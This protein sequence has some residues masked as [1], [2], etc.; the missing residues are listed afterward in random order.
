M[1]RIAR[2]LRRRRGETPG[3]ADARAALARAEAARDEVASR[4]AEVAEVAAE[5]REW[6]ERNHFAERFREALGGG[7]R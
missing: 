6:R 5:L 4:G 2:L 7:A 1:C 3:Q